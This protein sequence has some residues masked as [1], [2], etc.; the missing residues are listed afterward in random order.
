MDDVRYDDFVHVPSLS[1]ERT[2]RQRLTEVVHLDVVLAYTDKRLALYYI[3][4]YMVDNA[5]L[6]RIIS[7]GGHESVTV[8]RT[9]VQFSFERPFEMFQ[10]TGGS[11]R[12]RKSIPNGRYCV[13]EGTVGE[14]Q[15]V[16]RHV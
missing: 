6:G 11:N 10:C 4:D 16:S 9:I 5:S 13:A 7:A 2:S 12:S 15:F 1:A 14:L 3:L 8:K